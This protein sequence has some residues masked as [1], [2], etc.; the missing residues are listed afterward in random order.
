MTVYLITYD[1]KSPGQDYSALYKAIK[2]LGDNRHDLESIWFVDTNLSAKEIY[3]VVY[4]VMDKNDNVFIT[5][6]T[7]GYY[8]KASTELW[9]WLAKKGL[10]P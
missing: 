4:P 2:S 3:N 10:Q 6:V 1:L 8:G 5:K 9:D 7:S